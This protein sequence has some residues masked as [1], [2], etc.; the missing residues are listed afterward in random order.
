VAPFQGDCISDWAVIPALLLELT[1]CSKK[2]EMKDIRISSMDP[3]CYCESCHAVKKNGCLG[4]SASEALKFFKIEGAVGGAGSTFIEDTPTFA[5]MTNKPKKFK[6]CMNYFLKECYSYADDTV[7]PKCAE[8]DKKPFVYKDLCNNKCNHPKNNDKKPED[9]REKLVVNYNH[10]TS[11]SE[12]ESSLQ[13][14]PLL[15]YMEIYEDVFMADPAKVYIH[16]AGQSIGLHAVAIV[17]NGKDDATGLD[18]WEVLLP[19]GKEIAGGNAIKVLKGTNH[20][21][22]EE[23][24]IYIDPVLNFP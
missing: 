18:Y 13:K 14:S 4:G 22:I 7:T 6:N 9:V 3:L 20:C 8:S 21:N 10:R 16:T 23:K 12:Q 15:S 2:V 24:M 1:L 11:I 17:G 5:G 19:F